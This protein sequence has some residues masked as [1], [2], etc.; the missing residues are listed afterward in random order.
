[1]NEDKATRYHR[2]KRRT[3]LAGVAG[4]GALLTAFWLTGASAWVARAADRLVS[5]H[6]PAPLSHAAAVVLVYVLALCLLAEAVSLPLEVYRGF[7][8]E[9]RYDLSTQTFGRWLADHAKASALGL[10]LALG[11]GSAAY[12]LLRWSPAWWWLPTSALLTAGSVGLAYVAPVVLF[13]LFFRLKP[14]D[15]ETLGR[16]LVGLAERAGAPVLGVYEWQLGARTRAANAALVGLGR[17]RRILLSDT[18]LGGY[19]EEEIEVILAPELAHHVHGDLWKALAVDAALTAGALLA[20]HLAL[21]QAV[22]LGG[23]ASTADVAGLPVLLLAAACWSALTLPVV[24]AL[25]RAHERQAD[26]FALDLTRNPEAFIAAMRRLGAQH[27]ADEEP[28][29]LARWLFHSHPPLPERVAA[30]RRWM[31]RQVAAG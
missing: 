23:L 11:A 28:S 21:R 17:T 19:S 5:M 9:R 30:A 14:L 3:R 31:S 27:L 1:M 4:G 16:R 29:R 2:L 8:L 13:P 20:G 15:R 7:V 22:G 6:S 24:N 26:R 18:L 25:S 10:G 12:A